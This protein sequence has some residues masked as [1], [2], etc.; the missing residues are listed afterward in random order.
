MRHTEAEGLNGLFS[1]IW[2]APEEELVRLGH[3]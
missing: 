3:L 2:N 1:A